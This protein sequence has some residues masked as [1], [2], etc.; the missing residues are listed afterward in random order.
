MRDRTE[1]TELCVLCMVYDGDKI[2]VQNRQKEDWKGY[3]FP[4]GHVEPGESFVDAVKREIKEETGLTIPHPELCGLKQFPGEYGRYV[5]F[6]FKTD[7]YEGTLQSSEEGEMRWVRRSDLP[8]IDTVADF[9]E[10]MSVFDDDS[11]TEFQYVPGKNGWDI[12]IR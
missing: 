6:L 2:L 5:V 7:C 1:K 10:L 9:A 3:V 4:G 11:L 12:V 8:K